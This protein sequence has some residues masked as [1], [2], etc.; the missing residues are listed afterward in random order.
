M[1]D[2]A[3]I[4]L[5]ADLPA[6]DRVLSTELAGAIEDAHAASHMCLAAMADSVN[7]YAGEFRS[8]MA[9]SDR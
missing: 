3:V 9:E 2:D 6:P 1:H 7:D 8:Q 4:T 5:K